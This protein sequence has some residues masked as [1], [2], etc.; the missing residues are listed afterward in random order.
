LPGKAFEARVREVAPAA[1]PQSRTYRVKLT[2]AQPGTAVRL[3]M[4]GD[5][6]L[7][8]SISGDSAAAS[9][10][11]VPATAIFHR[12]RDP[13]VWVIRPG[14]STLELRPVIV[15][16]YGENAVLISGGL[17]GSENIVLAGVHTVYAGEQ[18]KPVKPLFADENEIANSGEG[19]RAVG[20]TP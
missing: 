11:G 12:G 19:S 17:T 1:D 10:F 9:A 7:S 3:G 4:T 14:D 18:V 20:G 5:A 15:A 16:S 2:L 13:A 8:A 6:T